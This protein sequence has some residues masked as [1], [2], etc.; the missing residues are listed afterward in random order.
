MQSGV[1]ISS[2]SPTEFAALTDMCGVSDSV[3]W[4]TQIG[5]A[6]WPQVFPTVDGV[7]GANA[8]CH[9]NDIKD[10][11]SNTLAVGEVTGGGVGS[12]QGDFWALSNLQDTAEGINGPH[13]APA[14]KYPLASSSITP[15]DLAGF[16]SFHPGGCNFA[17]CDGSA[18][19]ISQNVA[20][21]ILAA[22]TTR[23][24]PSPYNMANNPSKVFSP[25]ALISGPP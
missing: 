15:A 2:S 8:S 20:Q 13:T 12:Q 5:G 19:F 16:A 1:S 3:D 7:F 22:L 17:M 14:G 11:T 23:N 10:G 4:T 25:E 6:T 21:S 18:H 9:I 24:G